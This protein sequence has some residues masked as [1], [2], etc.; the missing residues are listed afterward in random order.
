MLSV[1]IEQAVQNGAM[2]ELLSPLSPDF[3]VPSLVSIFAPREAQAEVLGAEGKA[4]LAPA[5][6]PDALGAAA[7]AGAVTSNTVANDEDNETTIKSEDL[8]VQLDYP[9]DI[10]S[11]MREKLGLENADEEID[12]VERARFYREKEVRMEAAKEASKLNQPLLESD[13]WGEPIPEGR[14]LTRFQELAMEYGY[15]DRKTLHRFHK[16]VNGI[17]LNAGHA[18]DFETL[19]L[20]GTDQVF[21]YIKNYNY[22][23]A[24]INIKVG[25]SP[26]PMKYQ[27]KT[28]PLSF[29]GDT[30]IK[31]SN[32]YKLFNYLY[33]GSGADAYSIFFEVYTR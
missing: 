23:P 19:D 33:I 15:A 6:G 16:I 7:M 14:P 10:Q 26:S 31:F 2:Y 1:W 13:S 5:A 27:E 3:A 11:L 8:K 32:F 9:G 25:E 22:T 28:I 24:S 30:V 29:Y 20:K 18:K 4:E 12:F 17:A 21:I